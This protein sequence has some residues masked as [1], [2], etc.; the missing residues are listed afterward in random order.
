MKVVDR[1]RTVRLEHRQLQGQRQAVRRPGPLVRRQRRR[2][3]QPECDVVA[4]QGGGPGRE[5][6]HLPRP[7]QRLSQPVRRLLQVHQGRVRPQPQR[8]ERQLQHE[9]LGRVLHPDPDRPRT[10]RGGHPEPPVLRLGQLRVGPGP[11]RPRRSPSSASTT[12]ASGFLRAGAR[13]V[14]AEGI[15]NA[16]YILYGL[17][18][19]NRSIGDDLQE[20]VQLE[21]ELRLPVPVHAEPG[22]PRLDGPE[23]AR[24]VLP[25]G[26]RQ[27]QPD[28][29]CG[30]AAS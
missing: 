13:A 26:G 9:V 27:L 20:L 11:T 3:L 17:F 22:V 4:G 19:T 8:P 5:G 28:R 12:T 14:F 24:P 25:I 10:Q 6:P 7:R 30:S 16:S 18:R 21:R 23:V 2:D 15:T 1:R 29:G